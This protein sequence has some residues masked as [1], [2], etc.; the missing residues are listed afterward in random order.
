MTE[1]Y[2]CYKAKQAEAWLDHVVQLK[3]R[4]DTL[5]D[6]IEHYRSL[7]EGVNAI[8]YDGMPRAASDGQAIPNAV[9][10]IQELTC[11]FDIEL[12]E[13]VEEQND[14]KTRLMKMPDGDCARCLVLRYVL[15]YRWSDVVAKM[16]GTL[17]GM[18]KRHRRALALAYD[19]MPL[20]YRDPMEPAI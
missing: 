19:V 20:E 15:G 16:G 3:S 9:A 13:Y 1:E 10:R 4:C 6:I 11:E 5:R 17:D 2:E 14:A 8:Q 12:A 18:M 7:A